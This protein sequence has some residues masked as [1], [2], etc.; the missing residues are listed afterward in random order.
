MTYYERN[1]P[2]WHPR[3]MAVFLTWRLHGSLPAGFS[4]ACGK[5]AAKSS[6]E[7]FR[8]V[9]RQ[10]DGARSGPLWLSDPR[11]AECVV[12]AIR[13]GEAE[14]QQY[15]LHAYVVMANHVHLLVKPLVPVFRITQGLKGVTARYANQILGRTGAP[16]WQDE[17]FD[18]WIRDEAEFVRV[19]RY[20]EG[21]PVAAG[22]VRSPEE[23][24]WSSANQNRETN[25]S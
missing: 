24:P 21:N 7:R 15:I 12:R 13:R 3:G 16:L 11:V 25:H 20:I 17:S 5:E 8:R 14:L 22:L 6:G 18:R 1:L 2:H 4:V 23:W 10:L 9:D 19:G